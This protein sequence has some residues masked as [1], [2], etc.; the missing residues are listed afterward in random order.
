MRRTLLALLALALAVPVGSL[1]A[2]LDN[3]PALQ[4]GRGSITGHI[5]LGGRPIEH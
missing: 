5:S 3:G 1:A 4:A 2:S